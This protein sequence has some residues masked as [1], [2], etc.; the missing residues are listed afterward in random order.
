MAKALLLLDLPYFPRGIRV[1]LWRCDALVND[2]LV[3]AALL[4]QVFGVCAFLPAQTKQFG[5]KYHRS[6]RA[7]VTHERESNIDIDGPCKSSCKPL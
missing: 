3:G 7:C 2:S 5:V 6:D 4:A 1:A